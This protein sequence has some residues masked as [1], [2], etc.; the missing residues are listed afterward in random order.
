M[1]DIRNLIKLNLKATVHN[2]Y[3]NQVLSKI[4]LDP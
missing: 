4:T 2:L 1:K 3:K